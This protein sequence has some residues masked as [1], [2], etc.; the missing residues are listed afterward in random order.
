MS[1][2]PRKFPVESLLSARRLLVP[3]LVDNR[4][5]FLS[6]L[7]G[8]FSL[9]AMKREGSIPEPLLPGGIAL[10]NP[11]LMAGYNFR[12]V[13]KLGK[14][15]VM[16]DQD[17]NENYQPC[18]VP[19]TGSLPEPIFGDRYQ[20]QKLMLIDF[21]PKTNIA[22]FNIDD[23]KTPDQETIQVDLATLK[24]QSLGK[25]KYGNFPI[26]YAPDHKSVILADGYT[27]NDN[28]LFIWRQRQ[29]NRQ[30]LFGT[31]LEQRK[32]GE[33]YPLSGI[34][35]CYFTSNGRGLIFSTTLH[36]DAGGVGYLKMETPSKVLPV[37]IEGIKHKGTGE[38]DRMEHVHDNTYVLAYNIDGCS[39][40]YEARLDESTEPP[41]LKIIQTL[42]GEPPLNDGVELGISPCVDESKK[43][44][45]IEYVAAFTTATSPSQIYRINP[46]TKKDRITRVS[47]ERVLGID[48]KYLSPGQDASY[49]TFDGLRISARLYMPAKDLPLKKPYP[50]VLYVHGGPQGQ[51]RPDFTW[52]SMPLIQLLT[53]NGFA[54]FVP[55]VRGSTGYGQAFMKKVDHDW[56]GDDTKDQVAGLKTLEK[57]PTIDSTRRG[58]IGRSYGGYMTL[59]LSATQPQL[60]KA[61]VDMFGPYNLLTFLDRLPET[62]K[63]YFYLAIGHPEKDRQFL[64]DRSPMTYFKQVKAPMMVIQGRNDPRVVEAES[65][66]VVNQLR[67]QGVEVDYLVF[68]DEGHGVEKFKNQVVCY[69]RIVD[70]FKRYLQ[71]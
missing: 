61:S 67:K 13:P 28:V 32:E 18:F 52:F 12:V 2:S 43:P 54:V 19:L 40:V 23:R 9:Y 5:Y 69:N 29:P 10:Q 45:T 38:F 59:W 65:A 48:Q 53:L 66:D 16:I 11:H 17:G 68:E 58:V 3:Q 31:P 71:R 27:A 35:R 22:Y 47:E 46:A 39:W 63:T 56:G 1:A 21:D 50:L 25:S 20:G 15:L 60:W 30:V 49:T 70:F 34:G 7:A 24:T 44:V 64:V 36:N 14:V 51:E 26:G 41:R 42:I 37:P 8:A 57:N 33:T 6:D 4:I 55:N 62:W